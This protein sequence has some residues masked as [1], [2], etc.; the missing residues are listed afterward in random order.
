MIAMA[1][2]LVM[3]A[4]C[5]PSL[6]AREKA[7]D[8]DPR[9]LV[10]RG[11]EYMGGAR[12]L[13]AIERVRFEF[14]IQW[15][16]STFTDVPFPDR[17]GYELNTDV[18]D[19][20]QKAWRNT[21]R[22]PVGAEWRTMIDLVRG[23]VA[24]RSFGGA[25]APLNVAYVDERDELFAYTP[26]RLML[27]AAESNPRAD[28]DTTIAGVP[29]VRLQFTSDRLPVTL[30][31]RAADGLPAFAR[32]RAAAPNDFGLVPWGEMDVEVWYSQWTP[33]AG[34]ITLPTQWDVRRFGRPYKRFT[35]LHAEFNGTF[36]PDSFAIDDALT[37]AYRRT[38]VKPMHDVPLDSARVSPDDADFIEFR[39]FGAPTGAVRV[40]GR[41][42]LLETGQAPLSL[43]RALDWMATHTPG[44][45]EVAIAGA[46]A[47][48]NGGVA[49]AA[50]QKLHVLVGPGAKPFIDIVLKNHGRPTTDARV[51]DAPTWLRI[52][53]DS[54][55]IE[56]I[57]LPN[58]SGT[59]VVWV[60]SERW[61]WAPDAASALDL[62][63]VAERA[64]QRGWD[65]AW[66]GSRRAM[67]LPLSGVT[68][69]ASAAGR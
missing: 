69:G 33:F 53:S 30:F 51:I 7:M 12:V 63:I 6:V 22:F 10:R 46:V 49:A 4:F 15:K 65:A 42:L 56:R 58:A 9:E 57:D 34:G 41:W 16:I 21:R 60:P 23:D 27:A 29:H 66:F 44:S 50:S 19:Y 8:A 62:R 40:G 20:S 68:A 18:R 28:G 59:I 36:A 35:L 25:F 37:A 24:V 52:G 26:D 45:V 32:F 38:S 54:V 31:L 55:R 67:R 48:G 5:P 3:M 61:V 17:V 39:T 43:N 1:V 11:L 2:V 14:V 13:G 47:T 64:K